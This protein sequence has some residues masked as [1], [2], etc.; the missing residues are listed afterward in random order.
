MVHLQNQ[1]SQKKWSTGHQDIPSLTNY[2]TVRTAI[3]D[4]DGYGNT[5]K[6]RNFGNVWTYPAAYAVDFAN[7]WYLP[8]MGQLNILYGNLVE[9]NAGLAAVGGTLFENASWWYWSSS[10]RSSNNAWNLEC[11]GNVSHQSKDYT[12]SYGP[13]VRSMSAF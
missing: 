5:Q 6:I 8:A 2:T 9:V 11:Y 12:N 10:E 1:A 7:G 3:T 4:F 13:R